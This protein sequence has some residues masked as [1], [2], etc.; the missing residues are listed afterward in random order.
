MPTEFLVGIMLTSWKNIRRRRSWFGMQGLPGYITWLC[1]VSA[2]CCHVICNFTCIYIRIITGIFVN[3]FTIILESNDLRISWCMIGLLT[4]AN[5]LHL[6][7]LKLV[8]SVCIQPERPLLDHYRAPLNLFHHSAYLEL[9]N[10]VIRL[11]TEK[12]RSKTVS[13]CAKG[14]ST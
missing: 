14:K 7:F 11:H 4:F 10:N 13:R 2:L 8:S 12:Q 6:R 3:I 1:H 5:I 9:C